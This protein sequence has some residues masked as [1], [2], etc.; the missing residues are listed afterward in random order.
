MR[1]K[2]KIVIIYI[3]TMVLLALNINWFSDK[4]FVEI[5]FSKIGI[6]YFH[7]NG[8]TGFYVPTLILLTILLSFWLYLRKQDKKN[9]FVKDYWYY[10]FFMMIGVS[11]VGKVFISLLQM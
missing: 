1:A 6:R 2:T 11:I 8:D 4:P 9:R 7:L 3:A 10:C 5:I